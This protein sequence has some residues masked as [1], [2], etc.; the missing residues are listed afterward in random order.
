M[1][2]VALISRG[3]RKAIDGHTDSEQ[4]EQQQGGAA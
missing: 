4:C 3:G 2:G 1:G